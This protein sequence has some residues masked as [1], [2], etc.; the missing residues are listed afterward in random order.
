MIGNDIKTAAD[1]LKKGEIVA[2]PT[3]TVYGLAGNA[4]DAACVSKIYEIKNRPSFNPLILHVKNVQEISKYAKNIPE[5]LAILM[6]KFMP[7]PLTLLLDKTELVPD[8][9]TAKSS[10]VAIRIPNH[11]ITLEL[12]HQLDFPLAAPSANPFGYVSPTT[13]LHVEKQ[14][15]DKI[16]Y[17]LDGGSCDVGIESTIVGIE[18][19]KIIVY[20][21]GGLSLEEIANEVGEIFLKE[22][23]EAIPV[24]PGM[25]ASHYSPST[26]LLIGDMEKLLTEHGHKNYAIIS[27]NKIYNNE[28]DRHFL[29]SE[30]R[31]FDEA[32]RNL[33]KIM[34][35]IDELKYEIILAELLPEEQL[36]MAI[37]DRLRR[38]AYR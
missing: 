20:R 3:E 6:K 14:L 31:N 18:E 37:N 16:S 29:L 10:R 1:L 32:A 28:K 23:N 7:G 36:G 33:F 11:V 4:L 17:I 27:F 35:V 9:V 22:N 19:E 24:T 25:L 26:T 12:L 2:I 13:A 30:T 38:A 8:I 21:K 15:G 5:R 34:R